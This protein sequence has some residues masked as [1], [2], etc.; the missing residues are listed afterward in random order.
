MLKKLWFEK[1]FTPYL[2]FTMYES[3][4]MLEPLNERPVDD[5]TYLPRHKPISV[6]IHDA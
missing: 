4:V 5:L 6:A 2:H 3:E 1:E